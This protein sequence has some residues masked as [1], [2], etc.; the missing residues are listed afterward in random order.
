MADIFGWV[1]KILVVDLTTSVIYTVPTTN[2]V[3][4][5]IGGRALAVK[6]YWDE[7]P[8]SCGALDKENIVV[9]ASGPAGGTLAC[10]SSRT[11]IVTKSLKTRPQSYMTSTPGGSWAAE[12]KFAGFDAVVV[13]GKAPEP[14]YLWIHDGQV[15][16]KS[17][18]RL[19]GQTV[20][21]AE[22]E[23]RKLYGDKTRTML[24]GPAGE[25]MCAEAVILTDFGHAT[26]NNALGAPMGAK[27]LK[28]IAVRGTGGVKVKR[29]QELIDFYA[30][31]FKIG[32]KYGGPFP[33]SSEAYHL[34]RKGALGQ[35]ESIED[36][37]SKTAWWRD[38]W[39]GAWDEVLAGTLRWKQEGCLA[40]QVCC[41][42]AYQ[43]IDPTG[44]EK[45]PL[46]I[47]AGMVQGQCTELNFKADD[48]QPV[49]G[50]RLYR[51]TLL[52][53]E[54]CRD[55]GINVSAMMD[56]L[57]SASGYGLL[58]KE[59]T[60]LDIPTDPKARLAYW[61]SQE[62]LGKN[63]WTD[64][65]AHKSNAFWKRVAE[66]GA[67]RYGA[68]MAKANPAS[69]WKNFNEPRAN[70]GGGG[71]SAVAVTMFCNDTWMRNSQNDPKDHLEK[72][73]KTLAGLVP[74]ATLM[75]A[76]KNMRDK[77]GP[78]MGLG[79]HW[80][81]D[82]PRRGLPDVPGEPFTWADKVPATVLLQN[83]RM[84]FDSMPYCG[85]A[86]FPRWL[87]PLAPDYLGDPSEGSRL[88]SA[89]LGIDHLPEQG[90]KTQVEGLKKMEA[91]W[92]LERCIHVR[93]GR[94]RADDTPTD[95]DF[96]AFKYSTKDEFN[97]VLDDYYK[98][99]GWGVD[100]AIPTRTQLEK[101]G[102]KDVADDLEKKY[103]VKVPA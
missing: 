24:I 101:L 12:L 65:Y 90:L 103:G 61:V 33:Q 62:F 7:V 74:D 60:G 5:F 76:S 53:L 9:F 88:S 72:P 48:E 8:P 66:I 97:K 31:H 92:T 68:E 47:S 40:C 70:F 37:F 20:G 34:L 78:I 52:G 89:I 4:K 26:G 21:Q 10:G 55:M 95:A 51:S 29:P 87:A 71:T 93:E 56:F 96:K 58:T 84:E 23:I 102:M 50:K 2:Y 39:Y 15:E 100:T 38:K 59:L 36:R 22:A 81:D 98:L 83:W 57:Q 75:K 14:V 82:Q 16:I 18:S 42:S 19:W 35:T 80:F 46:D 63:G 64:L 44:N 11:A 79:P 6:L 85:W 99:R 1:G 86:G 13:R 69:A 28:L 54:S 41:Q 32:S 91:P 25:N 73:E 49:F 43:P 27:N 17:A 3:P 45:A 30:T 94:R 67:D 77:L